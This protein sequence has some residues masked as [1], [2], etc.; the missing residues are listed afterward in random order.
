LVQLN[1]VCSGFHNSNFVAIGLMLEYVSVSCSPNEEQLLEIGK[2][3]AALAAVSAAELPA[4][5]TW[6]GT[7]MKTTSV[8]LDNNP[9]TQHKF[10]VMRG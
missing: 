6:L 9:C 5:P 4:N 8:P 10:S 2:S 3:R 1:E 7:H